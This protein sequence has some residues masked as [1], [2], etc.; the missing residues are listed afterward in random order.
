MWLGVVVGLR[1]ES[2]QGQSADIVIPK[3][4]VYIVRPWLRW[5]E[6]VA[7]VLETHE[8]RMMATSVSTIGDGSYPKAQPI[9]L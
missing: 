1:H 6:R 5:G 2:S 7:A 3:T 4:W 8:V 9:I